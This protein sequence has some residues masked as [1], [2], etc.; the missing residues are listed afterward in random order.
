M[1]YFLVIMWIATGF[2]MIATGLATWKMKKQNEEL[3]DL[4]IGLHN[5]VKENMRILNEN[6]LAYEGEWKELAKALRLI[7]S[8]IKESNQDAA[9]IKRRLTWSKKR[10]KKDLKLDKKVIVKKKGSR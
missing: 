1:F 2:G 5:D 9:D 10:E 6:V 4:M 8:M 3:M 7:I